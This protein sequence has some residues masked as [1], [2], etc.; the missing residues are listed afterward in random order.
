MFVF[1]GMLLIYSAILYATGD[2]KLI[3]RH[4]AAKIDDEKAYARGIAGVVALVALTP[5][6]GGV[7]ALFAPPL[8]TGI[9]MA[10]SFILFMYLGVQIMKKGGQI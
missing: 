4:W 10:V 2:V 9:V 1:G 3:P 8:V 6:L 5:V 7:T